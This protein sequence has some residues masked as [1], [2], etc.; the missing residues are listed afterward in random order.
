[1]TLKGIIC[2]FGGVLVRM[3]D[4]SIRQKWADRFGIEVPELM[5]AMFN[6]DVCERALSGKMTEDQYWLEIQKNFNLTDDERVRFRDDFFLGENMNNDLLELV[7][8]LPAGFKKAILSNAWLDARRLFT[9]TFHFD[10]YFDLMVISAEEGITKP[11]D[12][13]YH[14]TAERLN[15]K[16]WELLFVDDLLPNAQAAAKVGMAAIHFTD[17]QSAIRQIRTILKSQGVVIPDVV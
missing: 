2:D 4:Q 14:L 11:S 5:D 10:Q 6:S 12:E 7:K 16:P 13:I 15:L 1:M 8:S 9:E 3:E 17:T